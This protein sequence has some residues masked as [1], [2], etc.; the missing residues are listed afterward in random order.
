MADPVVD[1]LPLIVAF[2]VV[3]VLSVVTFLELRYF[4]T[5]MKRRQTREDLPDRAHNA[6]LTSKAIAGSLRSSGVVT[7]SADDAIHEAEMAYRRHDYRVAIELAEKAKTILKTEKARH[8]K[9]GDLSRLQRA[10]PSGSDA[11]TTKEVLQKEMPANF[12]QAK[13]TISL[14]E[15]RI[16]AGREAGRGTADAE[17]FLQSARTSFDT[18]DY[19]AALKLA[20]KSRRS[21]DGEPVADI[22]AAV[23]GAK[24]PLPSQVEIPRPANR[25]CASCGSGLLAGDTFCRKC[26]VKVERPTACPKCGTALKADDEFCRKCGTSIP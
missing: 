1:N 16:A 9:F 7:M 14:A 17:A 6:L 13:F 5:F 18:K 21:A 15:E 25:A 10:K 19:D 2:V 23:G 24:A 26:G 4:R 12:M 20:A 11:P 22:P 8:D 3:I